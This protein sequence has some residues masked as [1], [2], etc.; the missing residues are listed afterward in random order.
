MDLANIATL[1]TIFAA[2]LGA[3]GSSFVNTEVYVLEGCGN[4][5]AN[6]PARPLIKECK[7]SEVER[8]V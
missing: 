6:C 4:G 5:R 2:I 8:N 7:P 3:T 1:V